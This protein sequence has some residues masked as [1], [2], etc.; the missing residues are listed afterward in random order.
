M[1]TF[2]EYEVSIVSLLCKVHSL[3]RKLKGSMWLLS[4]SRIG[5]IDR[6]GTIV[7]LKLASNIYKDLAHVMAR[8]G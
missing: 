7:P 5:E 2:D 3:N 4:L 8:L 1:M 6:D